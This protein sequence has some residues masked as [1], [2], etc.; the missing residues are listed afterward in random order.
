MS[1]FTPQVIH[2]ALTVFIIVFF[3]MFGVFFTYF[4]SLDPPEEK[5]NG[6]ARK[7][8]TRDEARESPE[9]RG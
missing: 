3:L 8:D 7:P 6:P 5:H 1:V 2:N 9:G 4:L